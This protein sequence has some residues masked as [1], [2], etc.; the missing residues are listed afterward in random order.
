MSGISR[1]PFLEYTIVT[2]TVAACVAD[3]AATLTT[4]VAPRWLACL[5][6]HSFV[7]AE[8]DPGFRR[9]LADA[10]WLVP[11][12]AGVVLA[13]RFLGYPAKG[14]ITG[15]DIFC[16]LHD[17][18][19]RQ[20]GA[21]VFFLGSS[22]EI[23]ADIRQQMQADYPDLRVAGSWSPPFKAEF[24]REENAAMV[25][26]INAVQPDLLWVGLTAPKQEK[27]ICDNK[28]LLKV[29]FIGAIGAVFDFYSGNVKRSHPHFQKLG[30]EWLPRLL[31]EPRRLWRR[32]FISAPIFLCHVLRAKVKGEG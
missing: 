16:G 32:M 13:A 6:P 2:G 27:W 21:S 10:D 28:Q 24:S 11:D 25:A 3:I 29:K 26:A 19:N 22:E 7:V 1:A 14:R 30:L 31:Q 9:A 12:G 15:S 8:S 17:C 4:A 5:N 18:L 23:L 20:G